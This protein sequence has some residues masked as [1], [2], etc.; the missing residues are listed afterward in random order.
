MSYQNSTNNTPDFPISHDHLYGCGGVVYNGEIIKQIDPSYNT[1]YVFSHYSRVLN[2]AINDCYQYSCLLKKGSYQMLVIHDKDIYRGIVSVY[3]NDVLIGTIDCYNGSRINVNRSLIGFYVP[4]SGIQA[5]KLKVASKNASALNYQFGCS[6]IFISRTPSKTV[7]VNC[8]G[9]DYTDPQGN[10][11]IADN[12]FTGGTA[13]NIEQYT[14]TYTVQG[15]DKQPLYKFE[16][17]LDSG[18]FSYT[19][20]INAGVYNLKLHFSENNKTATGQRVGTIALNG[21]QILNNFDI[22]A[23]AGGKNIALI[24]SFN[25]LSLNQFS[26]AISNTLINA[27]ELN[28][29]G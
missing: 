16:R 5:F 14:G 29:V 13:W 3:I 17:S 6:G 22:F 20:P 11:W 4:V 19:I 7:L 28:A 24:K 8:G 10:L 2:D 26:L 1:G 9:S 27:I 18:T 25:N 12:Y 23:Q 15:T 21:T